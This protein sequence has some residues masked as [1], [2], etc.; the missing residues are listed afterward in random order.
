MHSATQNQITRAQLSLCRRLQ[1][2]LGIGDT[3]QDL[4]KELESTLGA[5]LGKTP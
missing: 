5:T 4:F 2:T 3:G 1:P